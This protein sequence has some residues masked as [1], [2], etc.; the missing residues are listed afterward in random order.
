MTK[1]PDLSG[2]IDRLGLA[3]GVY[4]VREKQ[5]VAGFTVKDGKIDQCAPILKRKLGYWIRRAKWVS[6]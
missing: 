4:Q 1:Q 6:R 3:D 2:V 5:F